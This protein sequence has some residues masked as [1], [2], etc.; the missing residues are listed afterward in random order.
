M[1][2]SSSNQRCYTPERSDDD[3]QAEISDAGE[4]ISR[5]NEFLFE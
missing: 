1:T 3:T 2:L 5:S 4:E